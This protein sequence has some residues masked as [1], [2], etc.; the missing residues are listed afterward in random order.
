[1]DNES[2]DFLEILGYLNLQ[3]GK[4]DEARTIFNTLFEISA[5]D[6]LISLSYSYCL[7]LGNEFSLALHHLDRI[8]METLSV[9][10]RS[11]YHL[12][13]SNLQWH[14]GLD[15]PARDEFAKFLQNEKERTKLEPTPSSL[16]IAAAIQRPKGKLLENQKEKRKT[17]RG[18][19]IWKRILRFVARKDLNRELSR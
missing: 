17:V 1:M 3:Y 12:L 7:T 2:K 13:R 18:E 14:L 6:P 19:S 4:V 15:Q 9:K 5:A 10:Q 11:G 16:L 8:P